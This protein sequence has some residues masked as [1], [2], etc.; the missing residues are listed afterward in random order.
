MGQ[1]ASK[2]Y[3]SLTFGLVGG[4]EETDQRQIASSAFDN[5]DLLLG[6]PELYGLAAPLS[7]SKQ[8]GTNRQDEHSIPRADSGYVTSQDL[9]I[10]DTGRTNLAGDLAYVDATYYSNKEPATAT[11]THRARTTERL[12]FAVAFADGN[13]LECRLPHINLVHLDTKIQLLSMLQKLDL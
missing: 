10:L 3:G 4:P 7:H 5:T 1:A 12:T 8:D 6:R 11:Q 2:K 13:M 9:T